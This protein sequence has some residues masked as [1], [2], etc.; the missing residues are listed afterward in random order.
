MRMWNSTTRHSNSVLQPLLEL[1]E[2]ANQLEKI[3][4]EG[5]RGMST[6]DHRDLQQLEEEIARKMSS[7]S[8]NFN[9]NPDVSLSWPTKR[10]EA[11]AEALEK[12]IHMDAF[13]D[14]EQGCTTKDVVD[15]AFRSLFAQCLLRE[16]ECVNHIQAENVPPRKNYVFGSSCQ[17][18]CSFG[19]CCNKIRKLLLH[20]RLL[21][22]P[23]RGGHRGMR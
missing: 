13:G 19:G 1:I 17:S 14:V 10:D 18:L 8:Q 11:V 3:L 6:V 7:F 20:S 12:I 21:L 4:W 2:T 9:Q 5:K 22:I 16:E 23:H 15:P